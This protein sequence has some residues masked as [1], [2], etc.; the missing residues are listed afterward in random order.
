MQM[1]YF[2]SVNLECY[3]IICL[4]YFKEYSD[5]LFSYFVPEAQSDYLQIYA[6]DIIFK[7]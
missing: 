4:T 5:I 2:V 6:Q 1:C 3:F 7:Q